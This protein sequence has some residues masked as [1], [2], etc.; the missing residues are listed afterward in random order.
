MTNLGIVSQSPVNT[1]VSGLLTLVVSAVIG[2]LLDEALF[3][4]APLATGGG[5]IFD[6]PLAFATG[7]G[8]NPSDTLNSWPDLLEDNDGSAFT[9]V[10]RTTG[11][12]AGETDGQGVAVTATAGNNGVPAA[13]A[14][15]NPGVI[16][17][18]PAPNGVP[19]AG[20]FKKVPATEADI[21]NVEIRD[22]N[23]P[24]LTAL[25]ESMGNLRSLTILAPDQGI[26]PNILQ[27]A[28]QILSPQDYNRFLQGEFALSVDTPT[29]NTGVGGSRAGYNVFFRDGFLVIA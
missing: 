6:T 7:L 14:D 3:N 22:A 19:L 18:P 24:E 20:L 23:S 13:G 17:N 1:G 16:V 12:A 15:G 8:T 4:G 5:D 2:Q 25:L 26:A 27:I 9:P 11:E 10:I 28:S 21:A 29:F